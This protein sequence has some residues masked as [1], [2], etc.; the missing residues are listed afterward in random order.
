MERAN[1]QILNHNPPPAALPH[2]KSASYIL[3][4]RHESYPNPPSPK[5]RPEFLP[6][7]CPVYTQIPHRLLPLTDG[8]GSFPARFRQN[9]LPNPHKHPPSP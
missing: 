3:Q 6:A 5:N 9:V 7:L 2:K 1:W 4:I 8:T